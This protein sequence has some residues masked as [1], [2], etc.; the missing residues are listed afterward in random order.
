MRIVTA[1][2]VDRIAARISSK[3]CAGRSKRTVECAAVQGKRDGG[4]QGQLGAFG[5][6][7]EDA[8][9][10]RAAVDRCVDCAIVCSSAAQ[11]HTFEKFSAVD[12]HI[13]SKQLRAAC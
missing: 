4:T 10:K 9:I 7:G 3:L 1:I 6:K 13:H 8:G 11:R 2:D 12:G 5:R